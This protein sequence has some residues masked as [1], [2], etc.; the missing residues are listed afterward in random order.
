[1]INTYN[2]Y[3]DESCHL[4]NDRQPVMVLGALLCE[5][6]ETARIS[7]EILEIKRSGN[8]LGELKWTKV[9]KS[10]IDFYNSLIDYFYQEDSL[11]FRALIVENKQYLN[12]N[13]FN[14]GNHDTFYYKMFY[15]LINNLIEPRNGY[16]IYLDI[17]D[18]R[19]RKKVLKLKEVLCNSNCDFQGQFIQ[20]VQ[21]IRSDESHLLQLCDFLLGAVSFRNRPKLDSNKAKLECVEII[22]KLIRRKLIGSTPPWE[23]KFNLFTF[24][25]RIG[26]GNE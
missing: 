20:R 5:Q 13:H 25:P 21:N 1:M 12:H 11:R 19:S 16:F 2:I 26:H 8:A 3:C 22:E 17:K 14:Q 24:S 15:Y 7:N 6:S 9:S 4:E 18:T 23:K 10:R